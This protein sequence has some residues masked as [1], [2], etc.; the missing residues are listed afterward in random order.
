MEGLKETIAR[1]PNLVIMC[2]W[3]AWLFL[4]E[5]KGARLRA[6]LTWMQDHGYKFFYLGPS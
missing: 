4:K 3:W 6:L 1:S 5:G 2:E